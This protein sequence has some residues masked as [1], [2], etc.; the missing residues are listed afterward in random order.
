MKFWKR[1]K[2]TDDLCVVGIFSRGVALCS[3]GLHTK[4]CELEHEKIPCG[5]F[6]YYSV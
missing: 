5:A 3:A 1:N 2:G 4:I 6:G